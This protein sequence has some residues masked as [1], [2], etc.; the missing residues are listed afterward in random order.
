MNIFQN[1]SMI[2]A[3]NPW[4]FLT[5]ITYSVLSCKLVTNLFQF[6]IFLIKIVN[7]YEYLDRVKKLLWFYKCVSTQQIRETYKP[8]I[9]STCCKILWILL[10]QCEILVNIIGA[11]Y[12]YWWS[13]GHTDWGYLD[14]FGQF[15]E[16]IAVC[17]LCY[18]F[19]VVNCS[20]VTRLTCTNATISNIWSSTKVTEPF[21]WIKTVH[22]KQFH[23]SII[24]TQ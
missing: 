22:N 23:R 17:P 5:L 10:T 21:D 16:I 24:M 13:H 1:Q 4:Y 12:R 8:L 6:L 14:Y 2:L 19:E 15:F 7:H 3:F 9:N 11:F 20:L 18:L